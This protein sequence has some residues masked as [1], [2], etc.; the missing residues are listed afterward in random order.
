MTPTHFKTIMRDIIE[1]AAP[2]AM[3]ASARSVPS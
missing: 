1:Q 3:G 2:Q